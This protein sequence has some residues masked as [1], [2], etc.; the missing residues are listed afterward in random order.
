MTLD[1]FCSL[2]DIRKRRILKDLPNN[3]IAN[4]FE[5]KIGRNIHYKSN[6]VLE[7]QELQLLYTLYGSKNASVGDALKTEIERVEAWEHRKIPK[8]IPS[9]R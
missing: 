4:D 5:I 3:K 9:T 7:L 1:E 6:C 2:C 8:F